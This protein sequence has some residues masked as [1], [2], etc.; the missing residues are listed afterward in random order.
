MVTVGFDASM[1]V[2][3]KACLNTNLNG[4]AYSKLK[5]HYRTPL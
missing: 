4:V 3:I 1:H 2:T 5:F